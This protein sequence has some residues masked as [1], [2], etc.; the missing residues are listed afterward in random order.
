MEI[1]SMHNYFPHDAECYLLIKAVR[2][3]FEKIIC[4]TWDKGTGTMSH[5]WDEVP[6]PLSH[7]GY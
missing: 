4:L 3:L 6:V 1:F 7:L 5:V 2:I